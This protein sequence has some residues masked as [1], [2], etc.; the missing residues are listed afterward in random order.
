MTTKFKGLK[1]GFN[2]SGSNDVTP[3]AMG[4]PTTKFKGRSAVPNGALKHYPA[5]VAAIEGGNRRLAKSNHGDGG[6]CGT[7]FSS[8]FAKK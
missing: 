4:A 8:R 1:T 5:A 6:S 7:R 2:K 3:N